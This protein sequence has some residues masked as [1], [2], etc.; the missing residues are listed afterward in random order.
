MIEYDPSAI[1]ALPWPSETVITAP[2]IG[3]PFWQYVTVPTSLPI[4]GE[5]QLGNLK[6]PIRVRQLNEV[7]PAA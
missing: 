3:W 4:A 1:V 6:A 5:T 2:L 7:F